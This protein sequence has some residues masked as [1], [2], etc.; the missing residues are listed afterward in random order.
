M[1]RS[2]DA[3]QRNPAVR[4]YEWNGKDGGFRYFDKTKA[5]ATT[6]GE[7]VSVALP[8]RFM[9]LDC[10]STVKGYSDSDQSGYWSNEVRDIRKDIL[11]V[12]T[13]KRNPA[14]KGTYSEIKDALKSGG[15]RFC[16]SVYVAI[17]DGDK[18][19]IANVQLI[20]AALNAWIDFRKVDDSVYKGVIEIAEMVQGKKG[21]NVYQSPVFTKIKSND[22]GDRQAN[23]L[24]KQ[25]QA[26]LKNYFN[27][28][29]DEIAA[30]HAAEAVPT[31]ED[32]ME[33]IPEQNEYDQIADSELPF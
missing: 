7:N 25:L 31:D 1:S 19:A 26:Y 17:R 12:R 20:G 14:Y 21:S 32:S 5:T 22:A 15:G 10:L 3:E 24:D 23:E 4:F 2:N 16:Q 29:Q 33:D 30:S 18:L 9:V 8:F 27:R 28:T 6:K 11:T 13:K